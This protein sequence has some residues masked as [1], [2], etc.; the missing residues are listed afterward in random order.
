VT[1]CGKPVADE[2]C[3]LGRG[4]TAPCIP[5]SEIAALRDAAMDRGRRCNAQHP[6]SSDRGARIVECHLQRGHPGEHE[7]AETG[8]TWMPQAPVHH[9]PYQFT[10]MAQAMCWDGT[11]ES[12]NEIRGWLSD[13]LVG[14]WSVSRTLDLRSDEDHS[15]WMQ[16]RIMCVAV[17]SRKASAVEA[18]VLPG[19]WVVLYLGQVYVLP[20]PA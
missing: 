9:A 2:P 18:L 15:P 16:I 7:E 6:A 10:P 17:D 1:P 13:S 14:A 19:L 5:V 20:S 3:G 8:I 11:E 12:A 4:H